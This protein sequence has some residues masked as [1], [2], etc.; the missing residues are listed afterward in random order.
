MLPKFFVFGAKG[1]GKS[2]FIKEYKN[3]IT[4]RNYD[5]SEIPITQTNGIIIDVEIIEVDIQS[6]NSKNISEIKLNPYVN[7]F[8]AMYDISSNESYKTLSH[9]LNLQKI[10]NKQKY[11][12]LIIVGNKSDLVD[13]REVTNENG[14]RLSKL[15]P[16]SAFFEASAK[17]GIN[18]KE[19]FIHGADIS[20]SDI[21][22]DISCNCII[23]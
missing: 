17:D 15:F 10:G 2:S 23:S 1:V 11:M 18:V 9:F 7:T 16:G 12:N 21:A 13:S 4:T 6:D 22:T 8:I 3:N 19:V 20:G 14:I 5:F